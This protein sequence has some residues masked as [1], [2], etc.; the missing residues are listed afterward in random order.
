MSSIGSWW[1]WLG[2]FIFIV[3]VITA[4]IFL[5]NGG[6][7]NRVSSRQALRWVMLWATCAMC[8]NALLWWYLSQTQGIVVANEK[9]LEFFTGYLI[10]Q[11]LS[12]DNMFVFVMIFGYFSVPAEYQRRILLYGILS[13]VILRLL[14]ILGGTWLV[15]EFHWI[16]Y[17]FGV[18]LTLTGIKMLF[19]ADE[20]VKDFSKNLVLRWV[21]RHFHVTDN[22]YEEKFFIRQNKLWYVTPL[23]LVL[24]LIEVSDLIFAMDSIPAIFAITNDPFIVFTSNIFAIL[25]LRALY[26]LL[27]NMLVR[28]HLLK[29]G[30]ALVLVFIGAKMLLAYW[31]VMPI[32]LA[33]SVVVAILGTTVILS[34]LHRERGRH[35]Y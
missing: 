15:K 31:F 9:A 34:I 24:V 21:R 6:K 14:V 13:A 8:F 30:I 32:L 29:Y 28:F 7:A 1:M 19:S 26:F 16:L 18:F 10:E 22:F 20:S 3:T 4:D 2:F 5:L 35:G 25:G 11:T 27:A 33:L 23:F 17:V 12:V